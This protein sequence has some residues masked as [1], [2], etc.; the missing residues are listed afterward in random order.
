MSKFLLRT[1]LTALAFLFILPLIPG[2]DFH[3]N[4]GIAIVAALA[5]GLIG[6]LVDMLAVFLAAFFTI[7]TL[8]LGLLVVIPLWL[9]GFWILPAFSLHILANFMPTQLYLHGWIPAIEGGLVLL[10]IGVLT[11]SPNNNKQRRQ[12]A[13]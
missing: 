2:I 8:G 6:F 4:F 7:S 11:S 5:F 12:Y 10:I 13:S 3:G 9:L 1:L